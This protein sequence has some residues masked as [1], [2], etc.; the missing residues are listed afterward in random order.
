MN[1]LIVGHTHENVDQMFSKVGSTLKV[2]DS[3][4]PS[5]FEQALRNSFPNMLAVEEVTSVIDFKE[6]VK[7]THVVD[8]EDAFEKVDMHYIK[9]Y[10]Q[11]KI[12]STNVN[13]NPKLSDI[14]L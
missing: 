14:R 8:K 7:P 11:F 13:G 5:T 12:E 10:H 2:S 3:I 1:F 6:Y 4:S 9:G